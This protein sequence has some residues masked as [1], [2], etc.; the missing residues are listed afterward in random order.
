MLQVFDVSQ[1]LLDAREVSG[2]AGLLEEIEKSPEKVRMLQGRIGFRFPGHEER[3]ARELCLDPSIAGWVR[4]MHTRVPHLLYYLYP[5]P[6]VAGVIFLMTSFVSPEDIQLG[7]PDQMGA[8]AFEKDLGV[9]SKYLLATALFAL[10]MADD[11]KPIIDGLVEPLTP[12]LAAA[13]KNA[14]AASLKLSGEA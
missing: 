9:I 3:P 12:E 8:E 11:W 13:A 5:Q 7:S 1:S 6:P 10:R 14:V 4:A 2:M